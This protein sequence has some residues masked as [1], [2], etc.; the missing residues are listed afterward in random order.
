MKL[1]RGELRKSTASAISDANALR[2]N[3]NAGP[4]SSFVSP[5]WADTPSVRVGHGATL[6]TRA[7]A[8]PN[9]AA[10]VRVSDSSAAVEAL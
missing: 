3:A 10:Q 4:S 9:W 1:A 6:F 2:P 8:A 7:P 5:Y